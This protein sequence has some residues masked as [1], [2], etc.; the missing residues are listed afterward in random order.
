MPLR[1]QVAAKVRADKAAHPERYC[2]N[3]RCL[4]R[5]RA[6]EACPRHPA[7]TRACSESPDSE[8][9]FSPD[10]EYGAKQGKGD[11]P[12]NCEYCGE[13]PDLS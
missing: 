12:V 6:G 10:A 7:P 11:P 13:E 4:W 9:C 2:P 1:G 8:H 3:P 5:L